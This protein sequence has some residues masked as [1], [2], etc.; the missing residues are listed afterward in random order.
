MN[1][2]KLSDR[3][4]DEMFLAGQLIEC[5]VAMTTAEF[6]DAIIEVGKPIVIMLSSGKKFKAV[7]SSFESFQLNDKIKGKIIVKRIEL[8]K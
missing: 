5:D 2:Y 3:Q 8:G 7:V 6:R 4:E 1:I